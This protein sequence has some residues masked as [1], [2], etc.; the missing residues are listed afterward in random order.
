MKCIEKYFQQKRIKWQLRKRNLCRK[1]CEENSNY[2]QALNEVASKPTPNDYTNSN[3]LSAYLSFSKHE[4]EF[5]AN[6]IKEGR[7]SSEFVD[8]LYSDT[9]EYY[10]DTIKFNEERIQQ[11]RKLENVKDIK[12]ALKEYAQNQQ[13]K[14]R[15]YL[16]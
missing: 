4:S 14:N 3:Q 11:L 9:K 15:E 16:S 8:K 2:I 7:E 12:N 1:L 13:P 6:E 10:R 5:F